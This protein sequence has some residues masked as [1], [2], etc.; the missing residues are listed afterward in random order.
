MKRRAL[1]YSVRPRY[2]LSDASANP[3]VRT[4]PRFPPIISPQPTSSPP[5]ENN[6]RHPLTLRDTDLKRRLRI[7]RQPGRRLRRRN[8]KKDVGSAQCVP[9]PHSLIPLCLPLAIP[10]ALARAPVICFPARESYDVRLTIY[11]ITGSFAESISGRCTL[12]T[13][14]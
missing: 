6:G 10:P 4:L 11:M 1:A 3:G 8:H 5:Q 7:H 12:G 13:I 14:K 2:T 9:L